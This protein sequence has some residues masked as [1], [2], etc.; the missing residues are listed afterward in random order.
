MNHRYF[1][2]GPKNP[3]LVFLASEAVPAKWIKYLETDRGIGVVW[4]DDDEGFDFSSLARRFL[5][6]T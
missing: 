5:R 4:R 6:L 1:E 3:N 2:V